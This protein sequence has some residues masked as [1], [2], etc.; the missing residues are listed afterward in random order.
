ME[1]KNKIVGF[2]RGTGST[3]GE[4]A[5]TI[6]FFLAAV[7][8]F[9][10]FIFKPFLVSGTSMEPSFHDG[11]YL[12]VN[13]FNYLFGSPKRGDAVVFRHPEPACD[14]Y[15]KAHPIIQ[16]FTAD[17]PSLGG[18]CTNFIKRVIGL[19]GESVTVKDGKVF[20]KNTQNPEGMELK[21]SYIADGVQ[22]LGAQTVDLGKNEYYVL[23]DN[24]L[25]NA[26]SDSRTWGILPKD[27][28]VGR[29]FL[30]LYPF[31]D[32]GITSRPKY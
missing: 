27:H 24:R 30:V 15:M 19:P 25:P 2:F 14:D 4:I 3:Y 10:Y 28:I 16:R 17:E 32:I 31:S 22:T 7:I 29:S 11:Q 18:T 5:K 6:I 1:T 21:E 20:V 26:S 13:Q 8:I 23:G 12:V 9:K